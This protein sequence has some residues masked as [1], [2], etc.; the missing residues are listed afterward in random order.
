MRC[1]LRQSE[2]FRW[3][4]GGARWGGSAGEAGRR[5]MRLQQSDTKQCTCLTGVSIEGRIGGKK[6][7]CD[8]WWRRFAIMENVFTPAVEFFLYIIQCNCILFVEYWDV[9]LTRSKIV[10]VSE[11]LTIFFRKACRASELALLANF[12]CTKGA[13]DFPK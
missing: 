2:T 6:H 10:N 4:C 3:F 7:K 12:N 13:D 8:R 5:E 1:R 11:D 9:A